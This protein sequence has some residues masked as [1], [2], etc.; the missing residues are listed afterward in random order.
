VYSQS[1]ERSGEEA[2]RTG[3]EEE[4]VVVMEGGGGGCAAVTMRSEK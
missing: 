2:L 1:Y 4:E 3:G